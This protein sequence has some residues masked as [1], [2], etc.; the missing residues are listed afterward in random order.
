[1]H[2]HS[3]AHTHTHLCCMYVC[4]YVCIYTYIMCMGGVFTL[5][6]KIRLLPVARNGA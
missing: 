4:M 1:M 2:V 6:Y 3:F 5:M